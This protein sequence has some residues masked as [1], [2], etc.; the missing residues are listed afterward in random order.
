MNTYTDNFGMSGLY[1]LATNWN[2][3]EIAK[4]IEEA[5]FAYIYSNL[6]KDGQAIE[7]ADYISYLRMLRDAFLEVNPKG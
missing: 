3:L 1:D 4:A 2:S 5:M 6:S 7:S